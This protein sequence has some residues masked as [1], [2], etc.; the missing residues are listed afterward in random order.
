MK[1]LAFYRLKDDYFIPAS[2]FKYSNGR[3]FV[4][5]YDENKKIRYVKLLASP[6]ERNKW[7][8]FMSL[9]KELKGNSLVEEIFFD[10]VEKLKPHWNKEFTNLLK[11]PQAS[12]ST[13]TEI[14]E[15]LTKFKNQC[16]PD[17]ETP[18]HYEAEGWAAMRHF[19][20]WLKT[21]SKF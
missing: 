4:E 12:E 1:R 18:F 3:I 19:M 16:M 6:T 8:G 9:L 7:G 5:V 20:R 13:I 21:G 15:L 17:A 2:G 10:E 14:K 11:Q